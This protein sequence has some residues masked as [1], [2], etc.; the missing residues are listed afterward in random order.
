MSRGK[1]GHWV[2]TILVNGLLLIGVYLLAMPYIFMIA[3][4]F[5]PNSELFAFPVRILPDA[6]YLE[7]YRYLFAE[8]PFWGWYWNTAFTTV[9]RTVLA[10][11]FSALA[12]YA[13]AKYE[14]RLKR[15]IFLLIIISLM[16]PFQVL[17]TPLFIQMATFQWLDTYW[18][19]IVPFAISPFFIFLMR[20]YML[21]VP[22][23]LMDAARIDGCTEFGIFWRVVAPI[24]QPAFAV[25]GILAF[26]GAW[27]DYL[28]PLIVLQSTENFVLNIG[29]ASMF[30]PYRVPYGSILAGSFLA[31]LPVVVFFL[32]MQRQFIA[33]LTAGALKG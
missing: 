4:T 6:L 12:G 21:G 23:E 17:L 13:L 31:T 8:Y 27:T 24:M 7:N 28:W 29:I 30:G 10:M 1:T 32:I 19:V 15:A 9:I 22:T 20:Q 25:V 14:F 33:G 3:S 2:S 11:F 26:T 16:L 5:K 18:A